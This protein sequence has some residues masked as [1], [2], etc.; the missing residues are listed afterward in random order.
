MGGVKLEVRGEDGEYHIIN[1]L[2]EDFQ[3]EAIRHFM[4][5]TDK[6]RERLKAW[7][8][9]QRGLRKVPVDEETGFFSG[10]P[11]GLWKW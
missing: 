5:D 4:D 3:K 6:W 9:Y 2:L 11:I 1:P 10:Y 7:N 8:L